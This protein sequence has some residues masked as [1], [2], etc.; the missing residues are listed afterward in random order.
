[1][2]KKEKI[3][4]NDKKYNIPIE[5]ELDFNAYFN[6]NRFYGMNYSLFIL[7]GGR[8]IGKTTGML[9][10]GIQ[11]WNNKRKQFII[12]R[13]YVDEIDD[14]VGKLKNLNSEIQVVT[15]KKKWVFKYKGAI[16]GYG[17]ALSTAEKKKSGQEYNNVNLI[18]FDEY[19]IIRTSHHRYLTNEVYLLFNFIST[20]FRTRKDYK[21]FL[22]GN[23]ND[24]FPP[25]M[26]FYD[27]SIDNKKYI[28]KER[29]LYFE[30][31][32]TKDTLLDME[33]ETP[34][35][36]LTNGTAYGEYHYNNE[37][38]TK[39]NIPIGLKHRHAILMFR[40]VFNQVTLNV[41]IQIRTGY[42]IE[43][44]N[45]PI[46]DSIAYVIMDN[47]KLNNL[48]IQALRN[49]DLRIRLMQYYYTDNILYDS[50]ESAYLLDKLIDL[51]K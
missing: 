4:I 7:L 15:S 22:L 47:N 19:D 35:W 37:L 6:P 20:I 43:R 21:V 18:I 29:G 28:N 5:L 24:M 32:D 3:N 16:I 27:I 25:I 8:G 14:A 41:Y 44:V 36:K 51:I 34:L 17:F 33:K 31:L 26:D 42:F 30:R 23:N 38:L 49:S 2:D 13:R 50:K 39:E 11:N 12:L 10:K 46:K 40:L 1:M 9:V 48:F 45:K